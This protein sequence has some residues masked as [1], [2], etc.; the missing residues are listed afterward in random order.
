MAVKSKFQDKCVVPAVYLQEESTF[1]EDSEHQQSITF[2]T[3]K[4]MS[5]VGDAI[6]SIDLNNC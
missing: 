5:V 3:D 2:P 1:F 6:V 4:F